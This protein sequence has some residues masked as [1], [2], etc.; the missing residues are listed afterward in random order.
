MG[1]VGAAGSRCLLALES[2][3]FQELP[4]LFKVAYIYLSLN[5]GKVVQRINA[6]RSQRRALSLG[7]GVYTEGEADGAV[8]GSGS[9]SP[10][11]LRW[12]LA[13]ETLGAQGLWLAP[14]QD[15]AAVHL[16]TPLPPRLLFLSHPSLY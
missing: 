16:L 8:T 4:S 15:F 2:S 9:L 14:P 10:P 3:P 5:L 7:P 11:S 13:P 1:S 12:P 6:S